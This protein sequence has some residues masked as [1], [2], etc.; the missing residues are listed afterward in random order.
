MNKVL[1]LNSADYKFIDWL[2]TYQ[3]KVPTQFLGE[4]WYRKA[5]KLKTFIEENSLE[6]SV[7]FS[8]PR[9]IAVAF[10]MMMRLGNRVQSRLVNW[11]IL[12]E[13]LHTY[14]L[15]DSEEINTYKEWVDSYMAYN[16]TDARPEEE[17][18]AEYNAKAE[19]ILQSG[20][21]DII[22]EFV[23]HELS[24]NVNVEQ[25]EEEVEDVELLK[26]VSRIMLKYTKGSVKKEWQSLLDS[27]SV[28]MKRGGGVGKMFV[29]H[30]DEI[31]NMYDEYANI[32]GL[33]HETA[34]K[35]IAQK[36]KLSVK[37]VR[38]VVEGDYIPDDEYGNGGSIDGYEIVVVA[39]GLEKDGRQII[40][41][42]F[43]INSDNVT[44]AKE[45]AKEM[46][47]KEMY[48]SDFHIKEILT[49]E[50]YRGK[51]LSKKFDTGGGVEIKEGQDYLWGRPVGKNYKYTINKIPNL[52]LTI[53]KFVEGKRPNNNYAFLSVPMNVDASIV[54][55]LLNKAGC[56]YHSNN[57]YYCDF[58]RYDLSEDEVKT[59]INN[60]KKISKGGLVDVSDLIVGKD[61]AIVDFGMGY[62]LN[63]WEFHGEI[64]PNEYVFVSSKLFEDYKEQV[65]TK[66]E[67]LELIKDG[68]IAENESVNDFE[69]FNKYARG[70]GFQDE[71]RQMVLNQNKQIKHHTEELPKAVKKSKHVPAWVVAKVN[72]S[73]NDISDATHYLDG[74][75]Q[76][77]T[78]GNMASKWFK[79]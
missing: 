14:E 13:Y 38:A 52:S 23:E 24:A 45:I 42:R 8:D 70:G 11:F 9:L 12:R 63:D 46:W 74:E 47:E 10:E 57:T 18:L 28:K 67:L 1:A 76:Y 78:G 35:K 25:V 19:Y 37:N 71:N 61:Y 73:A 69:D 48:N 27:L 16:F 4:D 6:E 7:T 50:E 43:Y 49:D 75:D 40:K 29:W 68:A 21:N 62:W 60:F 31:K 66:D 15:Q 77:K 41:D 72:R 54:S 51:Y 55:D 5:K 3:S 20:I 33:S 56:V 34:L 79:N 58:S 39:K 30:Y 26:E 65:F 53:G 32:N 64:R 17:V 2:N 36:L 44:K 22:P 59:I